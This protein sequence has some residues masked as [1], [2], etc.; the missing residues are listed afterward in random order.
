MYLPND[1]TTFGIIVFELESIKALSVLSPTHLK[2]L[3]KSRTVI[4]WIA[5]YFKYKANFIWEPDWQVV[6]HHTCYL[7]YIDFPFK[8]TMGRSLWN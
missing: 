7:V 8:I 2:K 4:G 5:H 3:S 1:Q 6:I